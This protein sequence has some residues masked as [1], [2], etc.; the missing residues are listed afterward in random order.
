MN[1]DD[2]ITADVGFYFRQAH[3]G[4]PG[5][6]AGADLVSDWF[7]RNMRIYSNVLKVIESPNDRVLVIFGAGHLGWLRHDFGSNPDLR[8]RKLAEFAH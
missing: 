7:R 6:W 1:S 2:K 4:E 3:F 8:L 5:D